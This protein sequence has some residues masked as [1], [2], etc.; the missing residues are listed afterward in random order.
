MCDLNGPSGVNLPGEGMAWDVLGSKS[1]RAR[2]KTR[3]FA[4]TRAA[5]RPRVNW[6]VAVEHAHEAEQKIIAGVFLT[7]W[8]AQGQAQ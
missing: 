4:A 7:H 8:L 2:V 6:V 5:P 1:V 3:V